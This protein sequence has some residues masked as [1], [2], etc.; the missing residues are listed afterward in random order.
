MDE[1]VEDYRAIHLSLRA[2]AEL[3]S[4]RTRCKKI[5]RCADLVRIKD[6]RRIEVAG[7]VLVRQ[8]P[9]TTNVTFLT[10]EDE[11]GIANIIV[12][13][14]FEAQRRSSCRQRW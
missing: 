8:R 14:R 12:W 6:G 13:P 9:G 4:A 10:I 1:V 7:I 2:S 5:A 11:S 3:S